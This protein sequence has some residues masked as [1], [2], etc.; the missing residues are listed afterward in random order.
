ME[1]GDN[2]RIGKLGT[3]HNSILQT[4][5]SPGSTVEMTVVLNESNTYWASEAPLRCASNADLLSA[6]GQ[7]RRD[8]KFQV[9]FFHVDNVCTIIICIGDMGNENQIAIT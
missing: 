5:S 9:S 2:N 8:Y 7:V 1:I 6:D 3:G 4:Q